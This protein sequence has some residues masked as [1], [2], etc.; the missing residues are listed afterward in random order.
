VAH[1]A[2]RRSTHRAIEPETPEAF[3]ALYAFRRDAILEAI[4][5]SA[6][7]LLRANNL[8]ESI[9]DVI[10]EIG[11]ATAVDRV[12]LLVLD[13]AESPEIGRILD[14]HVWAAAG[15]PTPEVFGNARGTVAVDNGLKTWMPRLARGEIITGHTRDFEES[16]RRFF[17]SGDIKS[18]ACVPVFVGSRWWGMIGFDD[19]RHER[20]W[21]PAE[22]D[23]LKILGALIGAAI[24]RARQVT[25]LT[26]ANRIIENSPTILYRLSA[27][28]PFSLTYISPNISRYGYDSD[29][30]LASPDSW[31]RLIA[32]EDR[33]ILIARMKEIVRKKSKQMRTEFRIRTRDGAQIWL[34]GLGA[35]LCDGDGRVVAIEGILTDVTERKIS[36][37]K[38]AHLA[39]TD[40]LTGLAN[41]AAFLD[42]LDLEI[43]RARRHGSRF[44]VHF[45]DLD[46]FKDVNDTL[47]HPVGDM[48][49][50]AVAG[51]LR[52][53]VRETDLVARFGGDEFA[54]L[55]DEVADLS[56]AEMLAN[57]ISAALRE[58]Y[59]IDGNL[60][61][62]TASI[63][64][65]P[66]SHDA[67][68]AET[69]MQ[70]ADLALY[71][72]KNEG[73]NRYRFHAAELDQQVHE[74]EAISEDLYLAIER[75]EFDL[76]YQPQVEL[77]T[78]RIV[79]VEGLVRWNHPAR[80]LLLPGAFIPIA[81]TTGAINV[82]GQWVIE[83][84]CRQIAHWRE[85]GIAP[86]VVAVNLSMAQF[87]LASFVDRVIADNLA[88]YKVA[89]D[90]IELEISES[91]LME[92]TQR[93]GE[94]FERLQ[95]LGVRFAIDDFGTG[96]SSLEY[97]RAFPI[98]RLKIDRRF[99]ADVTAGSDAATIVRAAIGLAR[100]LG[101]EAVAEGV[102]TAEQRSFLIEAG[103][104]LGQGFYLGAP[105][106]AAWATELLRKNRFACPI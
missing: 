88:R 46:H 10:E 51:R 56:L 58:P 102:E 93:S 69:M 65:V 26:D 28:K 95:R 6:E 50:K 8:R 94:V 31:T 19:C 80:G 97:L 63:G 91:V 9:S 85:L 5:K 32:A 54:V 61:H 75:G 68:D 22:I 78:G 74:R 23:T 45:L 62:T 67:G 37:E 82:I 83:R 73:R 16:V 90:E 12:H 103:C 55:Q 30:L 77:A 104:T 41:R 96:Y 70:R 57:K 44:A 3:A 89:A 71:R 72:A 105:M 92:T 98:S 18:T 36:G 100:A 99:V 27:H 21:S 38:I 17:E 34:E 101:I 106:P 25:A 13:P 42:R 86:A 15:I 49:L 40:S 79:G 4:A 59:T 66:Y 24:G 29:A 64:V 84:A 35:A 87:K 2:K 47:G 33:P 60:I 43:A 48:L 76:H 52:T 81:E 7:L 39:R 20:D 14:H 53:C 1:N 11:R